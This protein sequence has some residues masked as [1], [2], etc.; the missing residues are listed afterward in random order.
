MLRMKFSNNKTIAFLPKLFLIIA[1]L[2]SAIGS[3]PLAKAY[4]GQ[5]LLA[6]AWQLQLIDNQKAQVSAIIEPLQKRRKIKPWP[7][8]D[9]APIA[10]LSF[11][12]LNTAQI[13][14]NKDSGQA[15]AFGPGVNQFSL[16]GLEQHNS[17]FVVISAHNESHFSILKELVLG[18]SVTLTLS[19]GKRQ[20]FIVDKLTVMNV[21]TEQLVL[22][23]KHGNHNNKHQINELILVTC[24]PFNGVNNKTPLRYV[25]RLIR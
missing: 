10:K 14:L 11:N 23:D 21:N 22:F 13:V 12:R 5:Y 6:R 7:W 19:S 15:L 20:T 9:F 24:Y 25:V 8:A 4:V 18:D 1:L 16:L 3:Y 2:S 17:D